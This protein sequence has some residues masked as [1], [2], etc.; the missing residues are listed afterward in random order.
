MDTSFRS[1]LSFQFSRYPLMEPR[2]V[3]KLCFQSEFGPEHMI[4]QPD[5]MEHYLLQEWS[6]LPD[7]PPDI[8][9][10]DIGNG[11]VRF[12]L[13][14]Q[15]TPSEAVPLLSRLFTWTARQHRGTTQGLEQRLRIARDF[16]REHQ[17][18]DFVQALDQAFSQW[19]Q[20]GYP[21]VHHSDPFREAYAPHYR[22]LRRDYACYF[23][24]LAELSHINQ[25]IIAIDGCCGSG[26]TYLAELLKELLGCPLIHMDDYYLPLSRRQ[27]DWKSIPGGNMDFRR[28]R[29]QVLEPAAN[30]LPLTL[31]AY[32]CRRDSLSPPEVLPPAPLILLEGSYSH[33]PEIAPWI[34]KKVF[35]TC[36]P[37][38]QNRRLARREGDYIS[39]FQSLWIP[40]EQRYHAAC[41][42]AGDVLR[43]NTS[44]FFN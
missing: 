39:V 29:E 24:L 26:K 18:A 25:G 30:Q 19:Q 7:N 38:A 13:T 20:A 2:D 28:L 36:D 43:V 5:Q 15:Y 27:G 21:A 33:H 40:M 35:L 3:M 1:I 16:S 42:P 10:E 11:L 37:Q 31:Q 41:P 4:L 14:T 23:P 6:S 8:P 44:D 34:R 32:D 9:P 22:L 12:H 17:S